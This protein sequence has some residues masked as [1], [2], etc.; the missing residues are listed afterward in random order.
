MVIVWT[1]V[2]ILAVAALLIFFVL[3]DIWLGH[4]KL[5]EKGDI[6]LSRTR[7][8]DVIVFSDGRRFF[9]SLEKDILQA[10]RH[11]HIAFFIFRN[12]DIGKEICELLMKKA[13]SGVEVRLLLDALGAFTFSRK[14]RKQLRKA[15]VSLAF[16]AKPYFPF[17]FYSLNRRNHRKLSI[18]D[19]NIAYFGGFNVGDEYLGR[20]ADMGDWRDY[21]LRLV[22]TGVQD[23]QTCFLNDW[24][25]ATKEQLS[26]P[27][28]FPELFDGR[29][30]MKLI[31]TNAYFLE[32]LYIDHLLR[33]K[34]R[35]FIGSPYFI[36]TKRLL[37]A[38]IQLL[39]RGVQVTLLIPTKKDHPFV[40]PASYTYFRPLLDH[41]ARIFHFY[42]GFYHAKVFIVDDVSCYMGTANFDR[43]SF[44]WNDEMNGFIYSKQLIEEIVAM[45][46][47][48]LL[49]SVE[50]TLDDLK[51]RPLH[52]KLST[53][54]STILSPFL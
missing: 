38:L 7:M 9:D 5:K 15:G 32:D 46:K 35:I 34:E 48:D 42:Q 1:I 19:G 30:K 4:R 47:K 8:S 23:I 37:N 10:K 44:D 39:D 17:F 14:A 41:G 54:L 2:L 16:S 51:H 6:G 3:L 40:R 52:E 43:R 29:H 24:H 45:T 53:K 25:E 28:Y 18:I 26:K 21:H 13:Q 22:G 33:A 50:L 49:R 36:P 27:E 31:P 20:K 11:I 12:D